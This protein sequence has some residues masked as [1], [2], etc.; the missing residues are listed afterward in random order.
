MG[1]TP[2]ERLSGFDP[3]TDARTRQPQKEGRPAA[4]S[5]W[6]TVVDARVGVA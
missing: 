6:S 4:L 5:G 1:Q 3:G 2:L